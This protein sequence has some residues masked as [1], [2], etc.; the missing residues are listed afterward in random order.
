MHKHLEVSEI[1][2]GCKRIEK[3][4]LRRA[5]WELQQWFS[6]MQV[7]STLSVTAQPFQPK[8][9]PQ[10]SQEDDAPRSHPVRHRLAGSSPTWGFAPDSLMRKAF[11]SH[12]KSS[13]D[14]GVSTDTSI[15]DRPPCRRHG[16][17][18]SHSSQSSSDSNG[19]HSSGGR[20]KKED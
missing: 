3:E 17:R 9:T 18:R 12:N 11:P 16:S 5:R 8:V 20:R 14:D 15:L 2:A 19:T 13:D 7:D 1:L 4:S 6:A 10:S